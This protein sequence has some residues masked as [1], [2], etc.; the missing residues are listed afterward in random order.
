VTGVVVTGGFDS[1][2]SRHVRL[3]EEAAKLGRVHVLLWDDA[4]VKKNIG[5]PPMFPLAERTYV[6][7]AIRFV[8]R[9]SVGGPLPEGV[10]ADIWAVDAADDAPEKR[11]F[12]AAQGLHYRAIGPDA[13]AGFPSG[14]AEIVARQGR[15]RVIVTGCYD[16]LH[17]GHIRFFEEAAS[18][19]D[20][21]VVAGS[22][23]NVRLLKGEGHPLFS[24]DERRYMVAAVR[25]VTQA[26]IS[27][28]SGWLDAEPEIARIRPHAYVV[29]E[30]GDKPE[31]RDFC[32]AHGIEY[33]VLKR[34]PKEGLSPRSST[35]LRGY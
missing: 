22:D 12:S 5:A 13:L 15:R 3:L 21:Y 9:V 8:D 10:Q 35:D 2:R 24:Q 29:N 30:D 14:P 23:A 17:S 31:K 34:T 7:E 20:L 11:A 32:I 6:L 19:G 28:G 27:T 4:T 1:L 26:L 16:W 33:V 25:T 18:L